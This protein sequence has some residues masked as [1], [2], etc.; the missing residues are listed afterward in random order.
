MKKW[1]LW[2]VFFSSIPAFAVNLECPQ[3]ELLDSLPNAT[4]PLVSPAVNAAGTLQQ[5]INIAGLLDRAEGVPLVF[6]TIQ[7]SGF[8]SGD[9]EDGRSFTKMSI[10]D[11]APR[12]E[13]SYYNPMQGVISVLDAPWMFSF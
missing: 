2:G 9:V 4:Q 12:F 7:T 3:C 13:T 5:G 11:A 6:P 10:F 1:I 8:P